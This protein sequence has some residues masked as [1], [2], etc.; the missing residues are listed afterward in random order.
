MVTKKELMNE[1][2]TRMEDELSVHQL[3]CLKNNF[4]NVLYR[5]ENKYQLYAKKNNMELYDEYVKQKKFEN[6]SDKTLRSYHFVIVK[7][8]KSLNKSCLEVTKDDAYL[9]LRNYKRTNNP[10]ARTLNNTR[11]YLLSFFNYLYQENLIKKNPFRSIN[12]IKEPKVMRKAFTATE[13]EIIRNHLYKKVRDRAIFEVLYHTGIRVSELCSLNRKDIINGMCVIKGKGNKERFIYFPETSLYYLNLYLNTRTDNKKAL[14]LSKRKYY[15][16]KKD[17][18][19]YRRI[20]V[21]SVEKMFL[22]Y[23]NELDIDIYPHKFRRTLISK[24]LNRNMP[25]QEVQT[26]AGHSSPNTTM[27]YADLNQDVIRM[28]FLRNIG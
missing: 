11:R 28:D 3:E 6:L 22:K 20:T 1:M 25:L 15:N 23:S 9:Y 5:D 18:M 12:S 17:E 21:G 4:I 2:L 16:K 24:S 14:F 27:T 19:S 7:F 8:L 26:L 10:S 13:I